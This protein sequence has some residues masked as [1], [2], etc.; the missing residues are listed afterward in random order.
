MLNINRNNPSDIKL[1]LK[2]KKFKKISVI[3]GYNSY[4]KSNANLILENIF[5]SRN[6]DFYFKKNL[7]SDEIIIGMGAG[8]ISKWMRD[9]K[10][11]L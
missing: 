7:I 5:K 9:L 1:I 10:S 3:T 2:N 6:V 11:S 8:S 4:Y